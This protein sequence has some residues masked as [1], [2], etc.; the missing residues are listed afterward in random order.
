VRQLG[1]GGEIGGYRIEEIAGRGGMG[2]VYRARQRRPD[3][4]VALK[5]IVPELGANSAFRARFERESNVA[6][7]IEHPNVIPVYE[8]GEEEGLLYIA[9]RFVEGVDL[10]GLLAQSGQLAPE[11]ATRLI[12]Q[13]GD[14]L[15]AAHA[16]GLVHRDIK[17]GNVLVADR[18]HVYL[19]DFGL[20]KRIDETQGM[21]ATGMFVG[22]VNYIAPEQIEGRRIDGR[23]DIYSLGCVLFELL[24]GNVPFPRDSEIATIFAHVNDLP[25]RLENVP[26]PLAEVVVR[27]M[28]K[29]PGDRFQS[30]GEFA[31]AALSATAATQARPLAYP[32]GIASPPSAPSETAVPR[33]AKVA[34]VV[35][36]DHPFFRDGVTRALERSGQIEVIGEAGNGREGLETIRRELPAVALVDYQMPE[37]DGIALLRAVV[38]DQL[39]TRVVLLSAVIDSATVF[40]AVQDGAAGYLSKDARREEIVDGVLKVAAGNTVVPA[41]LAAGLVAEIR[42]R[43]QTHNEVLSEPEHSVLSPSARGAPANSSSGPAGRPIRTDDVVRVPRPGDD[44]GLAN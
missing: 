13:V 33:D 35:V 1:P 27:A 5:I 23:A 7:Q 22:T 38:R 8:V 41:E 40:Q 12:W 11:R 15:D 25:P 44:A 14:A 29:R 19:T 43:A 31:R 24:S 4:T 28:A 20:S 42:R 10:G 9:M 18:D 3:R 17:P 6:A 30:A 26:E 34:V 32:P 39:T 21:T 16:R 2:L 37:M 36:D